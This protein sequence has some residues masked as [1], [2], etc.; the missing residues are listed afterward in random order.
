M[1]SSGIELTLDY[2]VFQ[3]TLFKWNTNFNFAYYF[4]TK[5]VKI[6]S[7]IAT[8][9]LEIYL[10]DLGDPYLTGTQ[11]ILTTVGGSI[12]QII[13][14]I[15]EGIYYNEEAGEYQKK[16][17]GVPLGNAPA[18]SNYMVVG[19]GL[20]DFQLGWGNTFSYKNFYLNFFLRGVF[21]HSLVNVSNARYGE[22][23]T[24]AIQS[25]MGIAMEFIQAQDGIQYSSVHVEKASYLKLDN[26]AF[27]YNFN[28][29]DNKYISSLKV[30]LAG[31]NLFTITDYSGVEPEVRYVD[32]N[33]DN[34]PLAPGIDRE[35]TYFST[36]TFSLGISVLF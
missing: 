8:S 35:T 1:E 15:Y 6:T 11:V 14:P 7:G 3:K 33:D 28:L 30:Y 29:P 16:F 22:P 17:E 20:P 9:D 31:Q 12:G 34:N 19:D 13:A 23:S 27:G 36:R 24:I 2:D 32:T 10:G 25:G 18:D 5:L 26:F 4:D 21:G